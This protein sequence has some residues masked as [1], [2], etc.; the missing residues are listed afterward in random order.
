MFDGDS[1]GGTALTIWECPEMNLVTHEEEEGKVVSGWSCVYCPYP[2]RGPPKFHKH[3][4]ATKALAHV[5]IMKGHN[6]SI[7]KGVIPYA[8]KISIKLCIMWSALRKGRET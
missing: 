6:I 1:D 7:C 3:I 2:A 8:K 5:L 4:N